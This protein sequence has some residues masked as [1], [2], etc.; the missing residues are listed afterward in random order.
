[1]KKMV[2]D[3]KQHQ[4]NL[5][6]LRILYVLPGYPR[7]ANGHL[8]YAS[9]LIDKMKDKHDISVF[10]PDD[11]AE[12]TMHCHKVNDINV[13]KLMIPM[14]ISRQTPIRTL[15]VWLRFFP[16][17]IYQ[18]YK[19][20]ESREIQVIH[21]TYHSYNYIFRILCF[22]KGIKYI[23]TL[24]GSETVYF[25]KI[26]WQH[27]KL[28]RFVIRGADAVVAVSVAL[29][30]SAGDVFP[31]ISDITAIHNGIDTEEVQSVDQNNVIVDFPLELPDRYCLIVGRLHP[32]KGI[33]IAINSWNE[34]YAHD[35]EIYLLIVGD[36]D[37]Y[38]E[39]QSLINTSNAKERIILLGGQENSTVRI[40]MSK[41]LLLLLPSRSEGLP[42]VCLEAGMARLPIVGSDVGGVSEVIDDAVNGYLVPTE[43]PVALATKTIELLTDDEKRIRFGNELRFKVLNNFDSRLCSKAYDEIYRALSL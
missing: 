10:A 43:D 20:L 35:P 38:S 32:V 25:N 29:K 40:L 31:E 26:P 4:D 34:V 2:G 17:V 24:H 28:V 37:A 30:K 18:L 6:R 36:G 5:E 7:M 33:D 11:C 27:R 21:T 15:L 39:Y 9:W 1:M 13:Y 41:A 3:S 16:S 19:L 14:P 23:V 42:A 12:K 8:S 22:I